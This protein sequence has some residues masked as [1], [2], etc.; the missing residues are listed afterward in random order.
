VASGDE[1]ALSDGEQRCEHTVYLSRDKMLDVRESAD[2]GEQPWA[3][4]EEP[5]IIGYRES[6]GGDHH[7]HAQLVLA[8]GTRVFLGEPE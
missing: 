2:N 5:R 4:Y 8:D 3:L 6:R 1:I 7:W